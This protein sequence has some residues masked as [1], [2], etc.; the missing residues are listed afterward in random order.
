MFCFLFSGTC[1]LY[2]L[3]TI[4]DVPPKES[5]VIGAVSLFVWSLIVVVAINYA[6]FILMADNHGEGD[7]FALCSFLT[8]QTSRLGS[9]TKQF[10]SILSILAA[11]LLIGDGAL[12]LA[13]S[14]LSAFEGLVVAKTSLQS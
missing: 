11:C 6:I 10:V 5:Q 14:I 1:P 2:V 12:A 7:P 13:V 8:G 3:K 9:R 4:F